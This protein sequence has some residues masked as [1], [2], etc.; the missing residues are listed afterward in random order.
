MLK[1]RA[2]FL[3][4]RYKLLKRIWQNKSYITHQIKSNQYFFAYLLQVDL[5]GVAF[6]E[7][8]ERNQF[9]DAVN[10]YRNEL[11]KTALE[12]DIW[13]LLL[14]ESYLSLQTNSTRTYSV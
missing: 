8:I 4:L 9:A 6:D 7:L 12:I 3:S 10:L 13:P 14:Q 5:S 1:T 2:N 11:I